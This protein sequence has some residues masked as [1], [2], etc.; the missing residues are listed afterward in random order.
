MAPPTK[1]LNVVSKRQKR[2]RLNEY[3]GTTRNIEVPV[4]ESRPSENEADRQ[5]KANNKPSSSASSAPSGSDIVGQRQ[6]NEELSSSAPSE[7]DIVGQR[8]NEESSSS[9][10][11]VHSI[12]NTEMGLEISNLS[13][14]SV[15]LHGEGSKKSE[16]VE[17]SCK[18]NV[19]SSDC[20][21]KLEAEITEW[22]QN[23][24]TVPHDSISRLLKKIGRAHV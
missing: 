10:S 15:E 4:V 16:N 23:E 21:E 24:K 22:M 7:G 9:A 17:S 13:S 14:N 2:R 19:C 12:D 20:G 1:D 5:M 8:P 11:P 3:S 6:R 18:S